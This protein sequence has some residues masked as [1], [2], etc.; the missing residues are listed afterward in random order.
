MKYTGERL[1]LNNDKKEIEAEHLHRYRIISSQLSGMKVLDAGCGSGYGSNILAKYCLEVY[2]ID[3]SQ[4][5]IDWC[6]EKYGE[7]NNLTYIKAS[8]DK[9]PFE[10]NEFDCIVNLE[11]IEHVNKEIQEAFLQEAK[12]V[13]KPNGILIMST[14]NK[15]VYT[16]ESNYKNPYHV[17][18]FYPDEFRRF[19]EVE[20]S[21]VKMYNQELF[22]VSSI[23]DERK[24]ENYVRLLK[25]RD[26]E[27]EEKYMIAVCSN[28]ENSESINIDSVY[29]YDNVKS[30]LMSSLYDESIEISD[31][32]SESDKKVMPLYIDKENKF[33]VT[34]DISS[35]NSTTAFRFDPLENEFCICRID[36]V[37]IDDNICDIAPINALQYYKNG[38]VFLNIDPQF[39]ISGNSNG[40]KM[41]IK[42]YCKVLNSIEINK[43]INELYKQLSQNSQNKIVEKI[44]RLT[45]DQ[46]NYIY[47]HTKKLEKSFLSCETKM[48]SYEI[49]LENDIQGIKEYMEQFRSEISDNKRCINEQLNI[50]NKLS[51]IINEEINYKNKSLRRRIKNKIRNMFS[52][53]F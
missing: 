18:E 23:F 39:K 31:V 29:K 1:I 4:E 17:C 20:F 40:N 9:L 14:P 10:D 8:L 48:D 41:T 11:V 27:Q 33:Q 19:L 22:M 24:D 35:F 52:R 13:L 34:F 47:N 45:N 21:S 46:S 43:F 6:N 12:R 25:D 5:T 3:I 2:A 38:F 30:T 28:S 42:G 50:I 16:D 51:D 32:Y 15:R 44:Y 26:I 36:E 53:I 37:M 7:V 49:Q